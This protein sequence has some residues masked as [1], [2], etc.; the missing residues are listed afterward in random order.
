MG[1][2]GEE[3]RH[4]WKAPDKDT[5]E[6]SLKEQ[7]YMLSLVGAECLVSLSF[8]IYLISDQKGENSSMNDPGRVAPRSPSEAK[9]C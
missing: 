5:R 8:S 9:C 1:E 4:P 7:D 3:D 6:V 2:A